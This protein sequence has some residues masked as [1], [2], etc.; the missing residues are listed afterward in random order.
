[1]SLVGELSLLLAFVASGYASIAAIAGR[2]YGHARLVASAGIAGAASV[3]ALSIVIAILAWALLQNDFQFAYV[4]AYSSRWLPWHYAL[5]ALWVGQ[6]G[7]LLLWAWFAA[8]LFLLFGCWPRRDDRVLRDYAFGI[9]MAYLCFLVAV[10]VFAADPMEVS[11]SLP[12]DGVGLSPLLQHPAMLV[13]PPIVFLGYALWTVPFALAL[14]ALACGRTDA[15][16]IRPARTWALCAW[17]VLGAGILWGASW[18]YEELG[19]G[20][21]WAWDPVENGSLIPWLTGTALIHAMMAWQYRGALKRTTIALAIAT[22]ALCNFA[23]FLTRSGVFSSL[24][25]FSASPIGWLFLALMLWLACMGAVLLVRRRRTLRPDNP[26]H[27]VLSRESL[28]AIAIVALLL[29]TAVTVVGTLSAALS[30]LLLGETVLLGPPFYN[31]VLI[32][33]GLLLLATTA[34]APLLRWGKPPGAEQQRW[35]VAG[36]V[37]AGVTI[38]VSW[39]LGGRHPVGLSVAGL[40]GFATSCFAGMLALDFFRQPQVSVGQRL[41]GL[42]RAAPHRYAGFFIHLGFVC[43]AVGVAGSSL[44]TA[45]YETDVQVGQAV[46]WNGYQIR[47]EGLHQRQEPD[48]LIAEAELSVFREGRRVASLRPAKHFHVLPQEWTTEVAIH[49]TW[50]GDLYV[51]LH[52]GDGQQS[53]HVTLVANPLMRWLWLSGWVA[54]AGC[55]L[56]LWPPPRRRRIAGRFAPAVIEPASP[57]VSRDGTNVPASGRRKSIAA[58][59]LIWLLVPALLATL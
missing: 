12:R 7:S 59:W 23:T 19:W 29:L 10:M 17:M 27:S 33:T 36:L 30:S 46:D 15:H 16:W 5:S 37:L 54:A 38:S 28:V 1:M 32:P 35:L 43:L 31:S 20:G 47:L 4:A 57:E 14:A 11:V 58:S 22:F 44:G 2:R 18:A 41:G 51:I 52:S 49:S 25:A 26:M 53:A 55:L 50:R 9:A 21:Y 24:H 45:Q 40:A 39:V 42:L 34:A 8:V 48:K 3:G 56:R 13:H 6:A